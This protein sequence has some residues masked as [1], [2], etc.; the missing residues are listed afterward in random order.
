VW[1]GS[2]NKFSDNDGKVWLGYPPPNYKVALFLDQEVS[3]QSVQ[4]KD[5]WLYRVSKSDLP[6]WIEVLWVLV[7][8]KLMPASIVAARASFVCTPVTC[9]WSTQAR[10]PPL[11]L[12][13]VV[14]LLHQEENEDKNKECVYPCL[15]APE[16]T[17]H[18]C[19]W[20][21]QLYTVQTLMAN[22]V[23]PVSVNRV[24]TETTAAKIQKKDSENSELKKALHTWSKRKIQLL[25][26]PKKL[27][28]NSAN[29]FK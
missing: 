5:R 4:P 24:P 23:S 6:P 1:Y 16:N 9:Q 17:R 20:G 13:Y 8:R 10:C 19:Q 25:P 3:R 15:V 28:P 2:F 14:M 29:T 27:L 22:L 26:L 12:S 11:C 18:A 21:S 7:E